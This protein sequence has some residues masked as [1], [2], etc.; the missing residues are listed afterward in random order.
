MST[1][2]LDSF[3]AGGWACGQ[4]SPAYVYE[5]LD[6]DSRE[7]TLS[8][9][10]PLCVRTNWQNDV[11]GR[12]IKGTRWT[13]IS[14]SQSSLFYIYKYISPVLLHTYKATVLTVACA[15]LTV[16]ITWKNMKIKVYSPYMNRMKIPPF[17]DGF[18]AH[19]T[20]PVPENSY[21]SASS[22]SLKDSRIL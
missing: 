12:E 16:S 22:T 21:P 10:S 20:S 8:S 2:G 19:Q 6:V 13:K 1:C 3:L 14:I 17:Q 11:S 18:T 5:G 15:G 7:A 4:K 9:V